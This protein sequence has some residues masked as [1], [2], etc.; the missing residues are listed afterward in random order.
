MGLGSD[1]DVCVDV[2]EFTPPTLEPGRYM[3]RNGTL[4]W[5][6]EEGRV[7]RSVGPDGVTSIPNR[8]KSIDYETLRNISHYFV[9]RSATVL[10]VDTRLP[11]WARSGTAKLRNG[12]TVCD[13]R[14]N[15]GET[16]AD[17][18]HFPVV[19]EDEDGERRT[20]TR[21][22]KYMRSGSSGYDIQGAPLPVE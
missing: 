12:R 21:E 6:D 11:P 19:G 7:V 22:G 10:A 14:L 1:S 15:T 3:L 8:L 4:L 5:V 16:P 13:L 18:D 17:P 2:R 20:W 9:S